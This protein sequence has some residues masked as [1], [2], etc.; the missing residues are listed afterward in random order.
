MPT[1]TCTA[2]LSGFPAPPS[3]VSLVLYGGLTALFGRLTCGTWSPSHRLFIRYRA[4]TPPATNKHNATHQRRGTPELR[5]GAE[6]TKAF[7]N[8]TENMRSDVSFTESAQLLR[9]LTRTDLVRGTDIRDAP[10]RFFEAH[11]ILARHAV[12]H[13][14]GFWI[15][16]TVHYNLFAGTILACGTPT[17][18]EELAV[19]QEQGLLGCF[20]LTEALAGVQ[21][22]LVV[23]TTAE[24]DQARGTFLLQTPGKDA[25]KNWISQGFTADKTVVV[26]DLLVDGQSKGPHAFVMDFRQGGKLVDGI[27]VDDMGRKTTG[28]DLDN[29]WI[30][31]DGVELPRSALLSR[32][33]DIDDS[34]QYV[35][36]EKVRPFDMLGQR[37]FTG[38]VA[39]AQA[40][41]EYRR[42]LFELTQEYSDNKRTYSFSGSP[43][44]SDIPQLSAIYR[45]NEQDI[46]RLD[47]FVGSCEAALSDCL[48]ANASP[49]DSLVDAIATCKV[50]AVESSISMC[51]R[52]KQEVGSF[53][54]MDGAGFK[55]MDFLQCCK[56]AEGDS[57]ILMTKMAR[58]RLK[59]FTKAPSEGDPAEISLAGDLT[60]AMDRNMK[61]GLNKQAAWDKEWI[62]VY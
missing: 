22:G 3:Y 59:A 39:V 6:W 34:G 35:L 17:Q 36:K 13:G 23:Q 32:Y 45:E 52:L 53:A 37:L 56:F 47:A 31:F 55:H 4:N 21:S 11:R 44:L 16:F 51:F 25:R 8:A 1:L 7:V 50:Q 15:R 38:R 54:L 62:T 60:A 24:W 40:A 46:A 27:T 30:Q 57:R 14:P 43:V 33:A 48:R 58:D 19:Y 12:A 2:A 28:N 18:V 26:A 29:A 9:D 10:Q 5:S 61:S 42:R 41:L 49:P 20:S